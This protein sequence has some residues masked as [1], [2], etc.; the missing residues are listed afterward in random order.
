MAKK[1]KTGEW[2]KGV[3]PDEGARNGSMKLTFYKKNME[4]PNAKKHFYVSILKSIVRIVGYT[5]IPF[6]IVAACT[7]LVTSEL[8]GIYEE[9]V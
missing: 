2:I 5:L 7:T 4:Y 1:I 8:I 6:N 9:M 3:I